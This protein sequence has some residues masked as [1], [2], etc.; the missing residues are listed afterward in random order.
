LASPRLAS[1]SAELAGNS[2]TRRNPPRFLE[3][4]HD[5]A[6]RAAVV[7]GAGVARLEA[8]RLVEILD[9]RFVV[10]LERRITPRLLKAAESGLELDA[11]S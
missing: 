8:Q 10:F 9:R 7:V 3:L 2:T 6:H 1:A 4:A 5:G 11:A